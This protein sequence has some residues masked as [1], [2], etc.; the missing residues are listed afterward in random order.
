MRAVNLL[1]DDGGRGSEGAA[2]Q[3]TTYVAAGGAGLLLIACV[4]LGFL[5][6]HSRGSV[7][8]KREMLQGLQ[9]Q[10]ADAQAKA[11]AAAAAANAPSDEQSL[12]QAFTTAATARISWDAL[13][14]DLARVLPAGSWVSS[15]TMHAPVAAAV[16][17]TTATPS[18][19]S[20]PPA[21]LTPAGDSTTFV[22]SGVALSSKTVAQVMDRLALVPMI[23]GVSLQSVKRSDIGTHQAFQFSMN[24]VLNS[25]GV[26]Q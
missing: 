3:Q 8:D 23:S 25:A 9:V 5:F 19:T 21:A 16:T 20:T 1:Q 10:V 14:L 18:T 6:V 15:L 22:I 17:T 26:D 2:R 7:S 11:A 12:R 4:L 13:L 24:A